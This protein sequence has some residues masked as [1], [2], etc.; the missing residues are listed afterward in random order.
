MIQPFVRYLPYLSVSKAG[1]VM[2]VFRMAND[3]ILASFAAESFNKKRRDDISSRRSRISR[4][5]TVAELAER[6][7][8][9]GIAQQRVQIAVLDVA[10]A[11]EDVASQLMPRSG[12]IV[13]PTESLMRPVVLQ[14]A[15]LAR[16]YLQARYAERIRGILV[17]RVFCP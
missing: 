2:R 8:E 11:V 10:V 14:A 15:N 5:M 13:I 3:A 6:I 4:L 16:R 17:P 9:Y 1:L 7:A 12:D